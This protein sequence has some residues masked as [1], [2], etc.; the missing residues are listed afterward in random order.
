M[1]TV[2]LLNSAIKSNILQKNKF[3][4]IYAH[5][6]NI[7]NWE[8]YIFLYKL[9]TFYFSGLI[10]VSNKPTQSWKK[11]QWWAS[12]CGSVSPQKEFNISSCRVAAAGLWISLYQAKEFSLQFSFA[13]GF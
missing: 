10:T 13:E 4:E 6:H 12:L 2:T 11:A 8:F 3:W 9:Y 5:S 1:Y 7:F